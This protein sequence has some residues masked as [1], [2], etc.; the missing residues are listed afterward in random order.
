MGTIVRIAFLNLLQARRRSILLSVAISLVATLFLFLRAVSYSVSERMLEAATT[1][2]AGHVNVGGFFKGRQK[3]SDPILA[4]RSELRALVKEHVPEATGIIDRHRGWGR[5]ISSSSSINVGLSGIIVKEE[6][7]FLDTIRLAAEKE[8]KEGGSEQVFGNLSDLSESNS[9]LI[10]AAQAKKL[11]VKV[12]DTLT[13]VTEAS[14]GQ[15]NTVDL[16]IVAIAS[17]IGFMSNWNIFVPRQTVLDLY[18][19]SPETT[20]VVMVYLKDSKQSNAVME[21]L[22]QVFAKNGYQLMEHDPQPFYIKFDKVSGEDWLGQR[23]DLTIWSDE[24]SF[25]LWITTAIDFISFLLIGICGIIIAG[26]ILNAMWMNVRERT[27]EIGTMRAIGAQKKFI[28]RLFVIEGSLL[29]FFG[30]LFGSLFGALV[31]TLL[32]SLN[33]PITSDGIRLFLMANSV[34]IN[35]HWSHLVTTWLLFSVIA[36]IST[37]FPAWKASRL[38]PVEAL[39]YAK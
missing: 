10:F 37:L 14:G 7:R 38:R 11:E 20:G 35:L 23:L 31:L 6:H 3:G 34:Q 12:G 2:S 36:G 4:N 9:V 29:G 30:A 5:L 28:V 26:G 32:N 19:L 13:F 21:R 24:I 27:K 17:D 33:L 39:L 18:L 8:Y 22:R 25:V 15:S 16:K 1:L